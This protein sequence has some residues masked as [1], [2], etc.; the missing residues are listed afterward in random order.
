MTITPKPG[1]GTQG[2]FS[3]VMDEH[4]GLFTKIVNLYF[5]QDLTRRSGRHHMHT[6]GEMAK[7][8]KAS[9]PIWA[10]ASKTTALSVPP[11]PTHWNRPREETRPRSESQSSQTRTPK[12]PSDGWRRRSLA[13]VS[14]THSRR[15]STSPR[16]ARPGQVSS[17]EFVGAQLTRESLATKKPTSGAKL[18]RRSQ[19]PAGWNG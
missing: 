14:S 6:Y 18:R 12:L 5:C 19:T 4:S 13:L 17:S 15:G 11:S 7:P 10:T 3:G 8:G 16:C 1:R 9:R 2:L